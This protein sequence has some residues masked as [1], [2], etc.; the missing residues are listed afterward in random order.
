MSW[1]TRSNLLSPQNTRTRVRADAALVVPERRRNGYGQRT[2]RAF[3]EVAFGAAL[4]AA[5]SAAALAAPSAPAS[6]LALHRQP[7]PVAIPLHGTVIGPGGPGRIVL[8]TAG[9]TGQLAAGVY[10]WRAPGP[11]MHL[12]S[13]TEVDALL[14]D[15]R[16]ADV[17]PAGRFV[18]GIPGSLVVRKLAVGD[19]LTDRTL[20][21]QRGTVRRLSEWRGK[22]L[23][24]SFVYTRCPDQLVCPAIS[25]KFAYLQRHIDPATTHLALVSLDP[26]FDS[27]S[28]LRRYGAAF[29]ADP[30]RWSLLTGEASEV[31]ALL[32]AFGVSS[33][34]DGPGHYVHDDDL[35]LVRPGGR[36][37]E[38]I[39]TAGWDPGSVIAEVNALAG[40]A[41]NPLQRLML[42]AVAGIAS[43]C[44]GYSVAGVLTELGAIGISILGAIVVGVWFTWRVLVRGD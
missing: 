5:S 40:R 3:L 32:D 22:S 33:L 29:A 16:L 12:A 24:L 38:I 20:V 42:A 25:G 41:A 39:P 14:E 19:L 10:R 27:P 15:G 9:S 44:G 36:I 26:P 17:R 35:V 18:A 31:K 23:V 43:L 13:G 2:M 21:D 4:L 11:A 30:S 7:A 8:R 37:A 6:A 1:A 34:Q 28:V